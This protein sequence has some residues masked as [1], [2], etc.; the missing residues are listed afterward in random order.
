MAANPFLKMITEVAEDV[1]VHGPMRPKIM[2]P[3]GSAG[4]LLPHQNRKYAKGSGLS[5]GPTPL[6]RR[7]MD[8][9]RAG[10]PGVSGFGGAGS[11]YAGFL[12][13]G[14]AA[15]WRSDDSNRGVGTFI[16]GGMWGAAGGAM[17]S[18]GLSHGALNQRA[19]NFFADQL[20]KSG[21]KLTPGVQ[22]AQGAWNAARLVESAGARRTAFATGAMLVGGGM[23]G[24]RSRAHGFNANRG[25]RFSG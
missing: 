21:N 11:A 17:L 18:K 1:G 14:F 6:A 4:G 13:G 2:R 20:M 19:G 9:L 5:S 8:A 23:G 16:K 12:A 3:R 15:N 22:F 10:V 24:D 7:T 25:N